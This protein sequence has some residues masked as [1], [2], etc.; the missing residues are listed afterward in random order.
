MFL[1]AIPARAARCASSIWYMYMSYFQCI[2]TAKISVHRNYKTTML[3]RE[4]NQRKNTYTPCT[5]M[6]EHGAIVHQEDYTRP[7]TLASMMSLRLG[8]QHNTSKLTTTI[9]STT[10]VSWTRN[11]PISISDVPSSHHSIAVRTVHSS[12]PSTCML[13]RRRI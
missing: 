3:S 5:D 8:Y 12:C 4:M 6:Y 13:H 10:M 7:N 9:S 2:K 1:L 11:C